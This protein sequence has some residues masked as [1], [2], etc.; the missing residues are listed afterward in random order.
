VTN[1]PQAK[2]VKSIP[3]KELQCDSPKR[4][5]KPALKNFPD[6]S[7]NL[8]ALEFDYPC[9]RNPEKGEFIIALNCDTDGLVYPALLWADNET[10][11]FWDV[12][13]AQH[14]HPPLFYLRMPK[15][16]EFDISKGRPFLCTIECPF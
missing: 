5:S 3:L 14:V 10:D 8:H 11:L 6:L 9:Y 4:T 1:T 2:S 7:R 12:A 13:L 16:P 15:Q